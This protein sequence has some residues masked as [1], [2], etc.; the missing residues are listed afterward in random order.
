MG[1]WSLFNL[2]F[3]VRNTPSLA[4]LSPIQA[5]LPFSASS[6]NGQSSGGNGDCSW[7][8]HCHREGP[9]GIPR[10]KGTDL[11]ALVLP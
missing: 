6:Q 1:A 3:P 5:A 4:V 11:N 10:R 9:V 8:Q 7:L 2:V